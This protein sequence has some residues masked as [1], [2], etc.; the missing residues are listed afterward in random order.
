M[1]GYLN[2]KTY[3]EF[4]GV[5]RPHGWYV[6]L[7]LSLSPAPPSAASPPPMLTKARR[8]AD[9]GRNASASP[10]LSWSPQDGGV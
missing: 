9:I 2:L 10:Q 7:T 3:G 4:D 8:A 6:W 1:Q 5:D